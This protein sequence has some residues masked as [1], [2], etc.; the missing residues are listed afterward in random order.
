MKKL[1]LILPVLLAVV[2][3][4]VA[5]AA[6]Q[7]LNQLL[8]SIKADIEAKRLSTP[9]GNNALE[10]IDAFRTQAPYDFRV[11]PLVYEWGKTYV[12]LAN[13]A[14]A[15]KEYSKAAGYLN[16]VWP[17][18]SLT[19]GL[20]ETQNK[21]DTLYQQSK[22]EAA[23]ASQQDMARQRQLAQAAAKEKER[24]EAERTKRIAE[25]KRQ[26][27]LAKKKAEEDR[28]RRQEEERQRRVA[29]EKNAKAPAPQTAKANVTAPIAVAVAP[30]A[31]SQTITALWDEAEETSEPIAT[32]PIS[33]DAIRQRERNIAQ[34]LEPICKAIVENDASVVVHTENKS[35]YRWLAVRL[36]LCLRQTDSNFRL[37]HSY[38]DDLADGQPYISLHP[39][40]EVSLL[41]QAVDD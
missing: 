3:T 7:D 22:V 18:A 26:A 15:A 19:P 27:E 41:R 11:V 8:T 37:R 31:S 24:V 25:E 17:V 2:F 9:A 6:K 13:N 39:A 40:R 21:L 28:L 32:Y 38:Q 30:A 20:E 4:Q 33:A 10:R 16:N 35:D 12:A 23:A 36:T 29:A 14:I 5:V 34:A 1:F